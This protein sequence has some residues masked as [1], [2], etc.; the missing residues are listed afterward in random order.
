M[1]RKKLLSSFLVGVTMFS[2]TMPNIFAQ[3][4]TNQEETSG[5]SSY[6]M[7]TRYDAKEYVR[8][9]ETYNVDIVW[10]DLHWIFVYEGDIANPDK[11]IWMTKD[12]YDSRR[13]SNDDNLYNY[14]I[15]N[16]I[17]Q[18]SDLDTANIYV[19]NN[20]DFQVDVVASIEQVDNIT[21][22]DNS[23]ELKVSKAS[24]IS[25]DNEN[26][27]S[28][29]KNANGLFLVKPTATRYVNDSDTSVNV[30]GEIKLSFSK[31]M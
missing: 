9:I 5:T 25:Y 15:L 27:V 30:T 17:Q 28:L 4:Y 23:A 19:V 18:Y 16:N 24:D 12:N 13:T 3:T 31:S 26:L 21:N 11:S 1:K 2:M 7:N 22:Y 10:N 20:S 29:G 8:P 14:D 6:D